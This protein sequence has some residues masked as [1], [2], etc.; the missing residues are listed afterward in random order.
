MTENDQKEEL[1]R[2]YVQAVAATAGFAIY[3]PSI[4]DES[5][6]MGISA[7]S[8]GMERRPRVELQLK[9]T[10]AEA[11]AERKISFP[12]KLKNYD[13]LRIESSVPR[14]LVVM[15]VPEKV[16]DWLTH[17]ETELAVRRC[18]YWV[19]LLGMPESQNRSSVTVAIPRGNLFSVDG[20]RSI[21]SRINDGG[22][23]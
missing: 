17:S 10:A 12:L 22:K 21:M 19:S 5:I 2:A 9:C 18:A 8:T 13:D 3:K 4:D 23:P 14:I 15:L 1:S 6:D 16:S 11:P 20:L 7:G